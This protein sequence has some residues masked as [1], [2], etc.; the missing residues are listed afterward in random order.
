MLSLFI[1]IQYVGI[2][3]L[4]IEIWYIFQQRNSQ[5]QVLLLTVVISTLIN[6]V[7]YLFEIQ[8]VTKEMALQAV[9][10][11]YIGKPYII[12]GTV[13]FIFKYFNVRIPKILCTAMLCMHTAVSLL[14]LTCDK[15]KLFYSS[16]TFVSDGFFP[17]LVLGHS[18][19]YNIYTVCIFL[20]FAVLIIIGI[21]QYR[22]KTN[23]RERTQIMYL[24]AIIFISV[25][26]LLLFLSGITKGYDSTLPAYLISTLL[27]LISMVRYDLLDPLILAKENV[28]DE[29]SDGLI[30]L[31]NE[32]RLIYANLQM[33]KIYPEIIS[34]HYEQVLQ[35]I[36]KLCSSQEK[37]SVEQKIYEIY[38]KDIIRENIKYGKMYVVT[39]ITES[40]NYTISLEK[41]TAIAEQANKAKSDF[42]AKMSHEIRTPINSVLGMDE[43]I[44]R[45]SKEEDIKKY[46]MDI[47]TSANALLSII[48]D[49][50]D[51]SKIESGKLEILPVEY[52]LDSLLNDVVNM[53][54]VKAKD[55]QLKFQVLVDE[56][57]PNGLL[58]DDVRIRQIL[59]NLLNNAV[60]YTP[61]G[62]I[63]LSVTGN[64][65][66]DY[67]IVHY[68]VS[69][70][71]IGIKEED[72]PKLCAAFERIE[73]SR[74]RSIEGTGLGMNIVSDLL[75][76][77]ESELKVESVYGK[78]SSFYFDLKQKIISFEEIGDFQERSKRLYQ[79]YHYETLFTAPS[80]KILVVDDNDINRK[81]FR[82]LLKQTKIQIQDIDS[83]KKCLEQ[84]AKEH[85][86][87]IFL[88][89]M[90]PDMDGIETLHRM[91]NMKDSM[92]KDVP[93]IILTANAV[94]GAKERYLGEGFDDFLSKPIMPEKLEQLIKA[95][96]PEEYIQEYDI[97]KTELADSEVVSVI[98][99]LPKLD[100][101]DWDYAKEHLGGEEILK[102]TLMDFY[103]SMD[104]EMEELKKLAGEL[105][106]GE[107]LKNYRIRV[108]ALKSTA[109]MVGALLLSQLARILEVAAIEGDV[110]KITVLNPILLEEM[111]KHKERMAVLETD[112][113]E[114]KTL[115]IPELISI[116]EQLKNGLEER[117]FDIAD[118]MMEKADAYEYDGEI[119]EQMELLRTQVLNLETQKAIET[120]KRIMECIDMVSC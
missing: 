75:H 24:N 40:Y 2:I 70:T 36:E 118:A 67:V 84:V 74:N 64:V 23:K 39:D 96:L 29:F 92:C 114:K 76:L 80:A 73:E 53:I 62:E 52:E 91:K 4:L 41:Q 111:K 66:G 113:P 37:L 7:G 49:I 61:Q 51:S 81:V 95:W 18:I 13:L 72:M 47:K 8:A 21:R 10:F 57:I 78:G 100:E 86:D 77:M 88:D 63:K 5:M 15:H 109:A 58:G 33:Q 94:T 9:K 115:F 27:L 50:L 103:Y 32:F 19:I 79:G 59:I 42:L 83:G 69:D 12:L 55:K 116:L 93:V 56:K 17:H 106:Q 26:G 22:M 120:T 65:S 117:D 3:I 87:L 105:T 46:A 82:N 90:M 14:V 108:H 54:Y 101:F 119:K 112:I 71:G 85:F 60:K 68:Q 6:F 97:S 104:K 38:E 48:N 30:V 89:H 98:E 1:A 20:Y 25:I 34:D 35:K 110:S 44:L 107:G 11:I 43:M 28:I 16:I 45:E 102:Q 31:D 99:E